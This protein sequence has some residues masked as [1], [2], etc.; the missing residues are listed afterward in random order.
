[1]ECNS[2]GDGDEMYTGVCRALRAHG[3]SWAALSRVDAKFIHLLH[4]AYLS[5]SLPYPRI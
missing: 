5:M 4:V 3:G 1:M 2:K